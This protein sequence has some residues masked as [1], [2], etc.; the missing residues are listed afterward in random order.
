[1]YYIKTRYTLYV[2]NQIGMQPQDIVKKG[3]MKQALKKHSDNEL[4]YHI[5]M[6][7]VSND[8]CVNH[9]IIKQDLTEKE[10]N[11]IMNELFKEKTLIVDCDTL[12]MVT[13]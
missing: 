5:I 11:S 1:M 12:Q 6:I 3:E 10:A 13:Y 4:K 2:S 9:L 8:P 7:P